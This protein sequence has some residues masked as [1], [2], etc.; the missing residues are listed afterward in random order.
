VIDDAVGTT[1]AERAQRFL[2]GSL[3]VD[4]R[5]VEGDAH[6]RLLAQ[7]LEDKSSGHDTFFWSSVLCGRLSVSVFCFVLFCFSC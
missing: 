1:E 7:T 3:L 2:E 4:A 5:V 6:E